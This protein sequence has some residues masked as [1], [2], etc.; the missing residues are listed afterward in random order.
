MCCVSAVFV[1]GDLTCMKYDNKNTGKG[2]YAFH[3]RE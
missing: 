2:N 3:Y 1:V